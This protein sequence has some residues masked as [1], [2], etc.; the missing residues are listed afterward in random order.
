MAWWK[1]WEKF[2][3]KK[4]PHERSPGRRKV[5]T[6]TIRT[7]LNN[8]GWTVKELPIREKHAGAGPH[9]V[10]MWKL[11]AVK[12]ERSLEVSGR[13]IDEAMSSLGQSMG[14]VPRNIS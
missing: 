4:Y 13:N 12:G 8:L 14:V 11:I 3:R 9:Q 5:D 6:N 1:I 7:R 10:V 2:L